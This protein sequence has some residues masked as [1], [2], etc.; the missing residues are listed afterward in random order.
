ML[1]PIEMFPFG[2]MDPTENRKL[3]H[4][5][6]PVVRLGIRLKWWLRNRKVRE[7]TSERSQRVIICNGLR[8]VTAKVIVDWFIYCCNVHAGHL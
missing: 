6:R 7:W 2:T 5:P 1:Q 3:Q 8:T 4:V